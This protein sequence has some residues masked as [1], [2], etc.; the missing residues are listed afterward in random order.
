MLSFLISIAMVLPPNQETQRPTTEKPDINGSWVVLCY[1]RDGNPVAEAKNATVTIKDNLISFQAKDGSSK[2]KSMRCEFVK[3][4]HIRVTE[5]DAVST[6]GDRSAT[7]QV[8]EGVVVA[9]KDYLAVSL[10]DNS[11]QRRG[12]IV[13]E[14]PTVKPKC[15][16]ILKRAE[17]NR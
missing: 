8:K 10:H 12:Q 6:T 7:D 17:S 4:G 1:E 16:V 11:E 15:T 14:N 5:I 9:T 13:T 3:P 2:I